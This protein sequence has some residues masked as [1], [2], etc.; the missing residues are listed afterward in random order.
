MS[1]KPGFPRPHQRGH[2]VSFQADVVR[3]EPD[4]VQTVTGVRGSGDVGPSSDAHARADPSTGGV[5]YNATSRAVDPGPPAR[6]GRAAA[7][8]S[9]RAGLVVKRISAQGA[10]RQ[11]VRLEIGSRD[12]RVHREL[13]LQSN[14]TRPGGGLRGKIVG[15]SAASA[16]RLLFNARNF[17]GLAVM[18]TL[19]Y[20]AEF[21]VGGRVVMDH[22]RRM[23]QWFH[24]QGHSTGLW[25][26]E[27][28]ARGA[29]HF[30]IFLTGRV[31]KSAVATAWYAIVGSDDP[32]HLYAGT[33]TEALRNLDA[34]GAYAAKYA[35]KSLQKDVPDGFANVGR[36][37]GMWGKPEICRTELIRGR[38]AASVVRIIRRG[39]QNR[40][41]AWKC[42]RR[43][44][45]N[46]R[47]GFTG[48]ETGQ[49]A[50]LALRHL[51]SCESDLI[52]GREHSRHHLVGPNKPGGW[53]S[54]VTRGDA[55]NEAQGSRENQVA[56][57]AHAH[58][59]NQVRPWPDRLE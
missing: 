55:Q 4:S 35:A 44:R 15:F 30:H 48:W 39:Y 5:G 54:P 38:Q 53:A 23:R 33:R 50:A 28:Q 47:S 56:L 37:W 31:D 22:W 49:I 24:R 29:P 18:V 43:F 42:R 1:E 26:K 52:L 27:F 20:P 51:T 21:P 13:R 19:T 25:F 16:R 58:S 45:D 11:A 46:G 14:G 3:A 57:S 8:S 17:P 10:D 34:A 9:G 12:V 6:P 2:D 59:M 40:R 7:G 32:R 36:F 41:K